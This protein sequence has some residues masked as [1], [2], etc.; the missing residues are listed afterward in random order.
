MIGVVMSNDSQKRCKLQQDIV[1]DRV[2]RELLVEEQ[3]V[4]DE[5]KIRCQHLAPVSHT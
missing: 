5:N 2:E 4:E 1:V 3:E